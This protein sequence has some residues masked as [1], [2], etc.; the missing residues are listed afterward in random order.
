MTFF[1]RR[2]FI[3]QHLPHVITGMLVYF[4]WKY[5]LPLLK[6]IPLEIINLGWSGLL[7]KPPAAYFWYDCFLKSEPLEPN[8]YFLLVG[9][10]GL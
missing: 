2:L 3:W 1:T 7:L 4:D 6:G 9:C 10:S 8:A 5:F